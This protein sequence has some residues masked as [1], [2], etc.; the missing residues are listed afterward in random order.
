[1][2]GGSEE[3][4]LEII[5]ST[6]IPPPDPGDEKA[7]LEPIVPEP[8]GLVLLSGETSAGKTALSRNVS[9]SLAEGEEFAGLSPARPVRVLYVDLE[10]PE[11]VHRGLVEAIGRSPNLGFVRRL[12]RTLGSE[13]GRQSLRKAIE[14]WGAD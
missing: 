10:S 14:E 12:P 7:L 1:M 3:T 11:N 13:E 9:V 8:P 5:P 2:S 6:E 4:T